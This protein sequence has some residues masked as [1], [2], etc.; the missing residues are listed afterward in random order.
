MLETGD[1]LFYTE[2]GS[3]AAVAGQFS[4]AY[5]PSLSSSLVR[6]LLFLRPGTIL[7]VDHLK[8]RPG[9][10][11]PKVDWLLQVPQ[12]PVVNSSGVFASNGK[13]YLELL[14]GDLDLEVNPL[15]IKPTQVDS[16]TVSLHY[17]Q[18]SQTNSDELLLVHRI[19]V[20]STLN[21][22]VSGEQLIF[23]RGGDFCEIMIQ[24]SA[25]R[26]NLKAPYAIQSTTRWQ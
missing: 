5:E 23:R 21:T 14:P 13:S 25:F 26:F 3:W 19:Q 7:V 2:Q 22:G 8:A 1:L 16:Y 18:N 12:K 20:G 11:L 9:E 17:Y 10:K 4:Q 6:Q 24:D 15:E